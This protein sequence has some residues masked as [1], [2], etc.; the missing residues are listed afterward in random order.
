MG[1]RLADL[2]CG[3]RESRRAWECEGGRE[4]CPF[5]PHSH[6]L[7]PTRSE[8]MPEALPLALLGARRA[9]KSLGGLQELRLAAPVVSPCRYCTPTLAEAKYE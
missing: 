3:L 5:P 4:V 2:H 9:C 7:S 8:T 6:A 1:C